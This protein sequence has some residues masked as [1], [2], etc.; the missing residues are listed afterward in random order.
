MSEP[1]YQC[2]ILAEK[3]KKPNAWNK[4]SINYIY[5]LVL[6]I[7]IIYIFYK[8][9]DTYFFYNSPKNAIT[10]VISFGFFLIFVLGAVG[11]GIK[12]NLMINLT[13]KEE[14]KNVDSDK[15]KLLADIILYIYMMLLGLIGLVYQKFGS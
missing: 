12:H 14:E 1:N 10:Y 9:K 7:A 3:P 11:V 4:Y 13:G 6:T 8:T 2:K 5:G 15:K